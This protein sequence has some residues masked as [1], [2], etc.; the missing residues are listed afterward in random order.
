MIHTVVTSTRRCFASR[1]DIFV[2]CVMV[3]PSKEVVSLW[4]MRRELEVEDIRLVVVVVVVVIMM[5][6]REEKTG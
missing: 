2:M 6:L 5:K 4:R 1:F 3:V